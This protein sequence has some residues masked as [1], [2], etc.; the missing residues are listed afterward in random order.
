MTKIGPKHSKQELCIRKILHSLRYKFHL[1]DDTLPGKP[2]IVFPKHKKIIFVHGCFWHRHTCRRG[3]SI[4]ATRRKF[5][6][7]KLNKNKSRDR[8]NIRQ[9]KKTGWQVLIVWECK[10]KDI[11]KLTQTLKT[12]L[13]P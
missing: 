12:F 2:D 10:T 1:H 6:H 8:K 3:K 4:P 7:E 11:A 5:W 13:A 9:L